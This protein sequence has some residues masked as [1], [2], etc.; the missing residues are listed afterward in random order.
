[1]GTW[2]GWLHELMLFNAPFIVIWCLQSLNPKVSYVS[3]FSGLGMSH[4]MGHIDFYPN[5]GEL[6]P[7]CSTNRGKPTDLDAIWEGKITRDTQ[8]NLNEQ[9]GNAMM[10]WYYICC[11]TRDC[12]ILHSVKS[13][14]W[15]AFCCCVSLL[16]LVHR[17]PPF[18]Q[19]FL[20]CPWPMWFTSELKIWPKNA[21]VCPSY[22]CWCNMFYCFI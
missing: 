12:R 14:T 4:P 1:M 20:P 2:H 19:L 8:T 7:G 10:I 3:F 22:L 17:L 15:F 11:P 21:D 9:N 18:W 16:M 13:A 6:M 5:G